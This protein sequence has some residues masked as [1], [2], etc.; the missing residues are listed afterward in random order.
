MHSKEI[1][2]EVILFPVLCCVMKNQLD[3]VP[4]IDNGIFHVD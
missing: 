3:F 2:F 4:L 1:S